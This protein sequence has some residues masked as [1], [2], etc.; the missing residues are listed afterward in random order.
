MTD[1]WTITSSPAMQAAEA[2]AELEHLAQTA[3]DDQKLLD[4][5]AGPDWETVE[6]AEHKLAFIDADAT[7]AVKLLDKQNDARG[8]EIQRLRACIAEALQLI[9]A[10]PQ[11]VNDRVQ[12]HWSVVAQGAANVL[13]TAHTPQES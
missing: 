1:T 3:A 2:A 6:H 10:G 5:D 11:M 12:Q 9:E 8:R 13:R 4:D 7:A